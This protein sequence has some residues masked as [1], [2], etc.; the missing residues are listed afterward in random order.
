MR[1][2]LKLQICACFI[3]L[4][5]EEKKDDPAMQTKSSFELKGKTY[6]LQNGYL[7]IKCSI[8]DPSATFWRHDL[9]F[10]PSTTIFTPQCIGFSLAGSGDGIV[11][12][13][14]SKSPTELTEGTYLAPDPMHPDD[15]R[16]A[17]AICYKFA[18]T[19][20]ASMGIENMVLNVSR[21]Q[22]RAYSIT[23]TGSIVQAWGGGAITGKFTGE[24]QEY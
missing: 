11:F 9:I 1:Y 13:V 22:G 23:F 6:P 12:S 19:P 18:Q 14:D 3:L 10:F 15:L 2:I 4:N 17:S 5:C 21:T 24:L 8:S 20:G 7:N 16:I